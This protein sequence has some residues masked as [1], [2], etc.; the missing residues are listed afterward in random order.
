MRRFVVNCLVSG[1]A[2][3]LFSHL[4]AAAVSRVERGNA[5]LAMHAVSHIAWQPGRAYA[6]FTVIR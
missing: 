6:G 1:A 3:G 2:A 5:N 4:A